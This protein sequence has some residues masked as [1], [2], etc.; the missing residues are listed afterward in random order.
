MTKKELGEFVYADQK[1]RI[2]AAGYAIWRDKFPKNYPLA[3]ST[4]QNIKRGEFKL[5]TLL[6]LGYKVKEDY[7][8]EGTVLDTVKQETSIEAL[9]INALGNP[10]FKHEEVSAFLQAEVTRRMEAKEDWGSFLA[11][12]NIIKPLT[13]EAKLK[14]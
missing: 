3:I 8:I 7:S 10:H 5:P 12:L 13:E 4:I 11:L 2:E 6:K 14:Y 9:V 1:K